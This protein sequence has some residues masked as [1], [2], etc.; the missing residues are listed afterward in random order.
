M[1][2]PA[3]EK[4]AL[5]LALLLVLGW[6]LRGPQAGG[7]VPLLLLGDLVARLGV[8]LVPLALLCTAAPAIYA[9]TFSF[10]ALPSSF[11]DPRSLRAAPYLAVELLKDRLS[12][13]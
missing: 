13:L 6:F 9:H 8:L 2:Y 12:V 5:G 11:L 7:G 3:G 1:L 4:P 10:L